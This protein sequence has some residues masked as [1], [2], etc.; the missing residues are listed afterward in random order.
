MKFFNHF[1][2]FRLNIILEHARKQ[3]SQFALKSFPTKPSARNKLTSTLLPTIIPTLSIVERREAI[4]SVLKINTM[5]PDMLSRSSDP[6]EEFYQSLM[7]RSC[8]YE[9][10]NIDDRT[11]HQPIT[12][13]Q[14]QCN[15]LDLNHAILHATTELAHHPSFY[16]D[17][18]VYIPYHGIDNSEDINHL[19]CFEHRDTNSMAHIIGDQ[20]F[21]YQLRLYTQYTDSS[22]YEPMYPRPFVTDSKESLFDCL[23]KKNHGKEESYIMDTLEDYFNHLQSMAGP[24]HRIIAI[25]MIWM[26]G[27]TDVTP[28]NVVSFRSLR[29]NPSAT[30]KESTNPAMLEFFQSTLNIMSLKFSTSSMRAMFGKHTIITSNDRHGAILLQ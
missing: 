24:C 5:D 21:G 29:I 2:S 13:N 15:A 27:G 6:L 4:A 22:S 11:C 14:L 19:I 3:L 25:Q 16:R 20:S 1:E 23:T 26:H 7:Q 18:F 9:F 28:Q 8:I 12:C 30:K 17:N 10:S